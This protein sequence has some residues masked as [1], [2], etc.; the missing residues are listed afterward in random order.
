[1]LNIVMLNGVMY[2]I[3]A[4][5]L[6]FQKTVSFNF[7]GHHLAIQFIRADIIKTSYDFLK[8]TLRTQGDY[9]QK[10]LRLIFPSFLQ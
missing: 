8:I 3:M 2:S 7:F 10:V 9:S 4:P 5:H 6:A 1:M